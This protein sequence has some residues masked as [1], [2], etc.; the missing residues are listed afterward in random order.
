MTCRRSGR[1][2][3]SRHR[4]RSDRAR[5]A[6]PVGLG[7]VAATTTGLTGPRT[8]V[9]GQAASRPPRRRSWWRNEPRDRPR[10]SLV[11]GGSAT[12][13]HR[14]RPGQQ[15]RVTLRERSGAPVG[16]TNSPRCRANAWI[17]PRWR[18]RDAAASIPS[19]WPGPRPAAGPSRTPPGSP[20]TTPRST[21]TRRKRWTVRSRPRG[22]RPDQSRPGHR[23]RPPP[24]RSAGPAR[25][26]CRAGETHA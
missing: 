25:L 16:V 15:L 19:R 21:R 5:S 18:R 10:S 13:W 7:R 1:P 23:P 14:D 24:G 3:R 4:R 2:R 9:P 6:T 20:A 17:T 26:D 22:S 11:R 12:P 8:T